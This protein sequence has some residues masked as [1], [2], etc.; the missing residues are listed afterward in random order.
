[1]ELVYPFI[2]Y[3]SIPIIIGL[4]I[5]KPKKENTYKKGKKIANTKFV[6]EIPYYQEV[7]KKYKVLA[8][9]VK[10]ICMISIILSLLLLARPSEINISESSMYNRDIFLC[11]DVSASVDEVNFEL[12]E[13]L[14]KVVKNL[15]GERFG[16]SIFNTSSV[17]LV[18]LTD[19]YEYILDTLKQL[20]KSFELALS[21]NKYNSEDDSLYYTYY[22]SSGTLV[23]NEQRGS[24]LIGDGLASCVYSFTD[25]D[26]DRSRVIIFSTDND[27]EG[28]EII[29]LK[30]A[31][32]LSKEKNITVFGIAPKSIS[33]S[34]KKTL[35]NAVESTGGTYYTADSLTTVSSI[36]NNIEQK[37]KSLIKGAKETKKIDKPQIPFVILTISI[38]A[39]FIL[40]KKVKL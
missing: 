6:K 34:N 31:A 18:P 8:N 33:D 9:A 26:E 30:E 11:L 39:L 28:Q 13:Q 19:D 32:Q 25:L 22:L 2:I 27:L 7:L 10:I 40:N 15:K 24:S 36:V 17:L 14:E 23:G 1:M 35:K 37:G 29:T 16:I 12:V 4:I 3:I 5:I 38:T 21:P 20:R